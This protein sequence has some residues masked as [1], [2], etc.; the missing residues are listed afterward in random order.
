M[1]LFLQVGGNI[2]GLRESRSAAIQGPPV[3]SE[4]NIL[5]DGTLIDLCGATLLWRS[6]EGMEFRILKYVF[7]FHKIFGMNLIIFWGFFPGLS[8]SPT[9]RQL[10]RALDELN[11]GRPQCPVGLH[12]LIVPRKNSQNI[13]PEAQPMVYLKCGHVQVCV[14]IWFH[15]KK[16]K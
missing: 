7:C 4:T 3:P 1:V 16:V 13:S 9:P 10:E 2:F 15:E 12:T 8:R 11:A 14:Y 6:V 5:V